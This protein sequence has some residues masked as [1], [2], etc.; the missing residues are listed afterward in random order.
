MNFKLGATVTLD[1]VRNGQAL[2][3]QAGFDTCPACTPVAVP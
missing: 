2:S 1:V 3:L